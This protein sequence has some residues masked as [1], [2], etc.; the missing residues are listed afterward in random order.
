MYIHVIV[1]EIAYLEKNIGSIKDTRGICK[2]PGDVESDGLLVSDGNFP[3]Q[4]FRFRTTGRNK[5]NTLGRF[6]Y[7]QFNESELPERQEVLFYT[8]VQVRR[9]MGHVIG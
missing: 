3:Q 6:V 2:Y 8:D 1:H 5:C 7:G 9:E 4:L